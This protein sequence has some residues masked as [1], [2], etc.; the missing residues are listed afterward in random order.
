MQAHAFDWLIDEQ[1]WACVNPSVGEE[2]LHLPGPTFDAPSQAVHCGAGLGR[3]GT[4]LAAH[5]VSQGWHAEAAMAG[6]RAVRPGSIET[7][8]QVQAVPECARRHAAGW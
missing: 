2:T 3:T 6:V 7:L 4:L 8:E 1:P 5:L